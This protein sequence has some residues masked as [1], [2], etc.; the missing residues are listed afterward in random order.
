VIA[1]EAQILCPSAFAQAAVSAYIETMPWQ[2]QLK[3][4]Q[5]TYRERRDAALSALTDMMPEGTTWT[6]PAGGFYIW[7]TLP[8]GLNSK[9][10]LPRAIAER[11]A[12]VP[13][14]GFYADGTG[15]AH[16]RLSYCFPPPERI[17]EGV[18][19]LATVI[20]QEMALRSTF[21]LA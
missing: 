12:Y 4:F 17:R 5:E 3:T 7:V 6:V 13:G 11:V 9:E 15:A 10:M 19:R 2:Q 8:N 1:S 18:R 20:E 16:M 14:T 21:G